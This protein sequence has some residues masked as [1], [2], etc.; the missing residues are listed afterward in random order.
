M[1]TTDLFAARVD[2]VR[3]YNIAQK[4]YAATPRGALEAGIMALVLNAAAKVR[5]E[6]E[7]AHEASLTSENELRAAALEVRRL[8]RV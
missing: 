8:T 4:T 2:A 6:A 5:A 3:A 1:T 7:A